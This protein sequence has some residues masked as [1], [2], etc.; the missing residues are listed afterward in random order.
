MGKKN[1]LTGHDSDCYIKC[2]DIGGQRTDGQS[3]GGY[4]C[5]D[6]R[7]WSTA[8]L[9]DQRTHDRACWINKSILN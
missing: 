6:Y 2:N 8:I 4:H 3:K 5:S 1:Q 9:V 7:Y